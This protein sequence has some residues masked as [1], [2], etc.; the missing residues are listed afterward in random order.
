MHADAHA[1][2]DSNKTT[3]RLAARILHCTSAI[4]TSGRINV[5]LAKCD[6][7]VAG[8]HINCNSLHTHDFKSCIFNALSW[9]APCE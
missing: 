3:T 5:H 6:Q 1:D 2:G 8:C 7:P 4:V 9:S